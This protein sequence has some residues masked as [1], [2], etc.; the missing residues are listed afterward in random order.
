MNAIYIQEYEKSYF[1]A[2]NPGENYVPP[3]NQE[4]N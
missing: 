3:E 4:E 2:N 1:E